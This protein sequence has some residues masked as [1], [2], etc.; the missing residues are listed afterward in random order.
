MM[1]TTAGG[2]VPKMVLK[3][4]L[5]FLEMTR[6]YRCTHRQWPPRIKREREKNEKKNEAIFSLIIH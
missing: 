5:T 3:E 2:R 1:M 4:C 6:P